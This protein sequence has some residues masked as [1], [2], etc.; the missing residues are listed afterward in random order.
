M[1]NR[2][3]NAKIENGVFSPITIEKASAFCPAI[4]NQEQASHMSRHYKPISTTEVLEYTQSKGYGISQ[5]Q[6]KNFHQKRIDAGLADNTKANHLIRLRHMNAPSHRLGVYPELVFV[7]SFDGTAAFS[8]FAGLFRLVCSNGLIVQDKSQ[9]SFRIIHK[10]DIY[11][12]LEESIKTVV[13]NCM[14][15]IELAEILENRILNDLEQMEFAR[16]SLETRWPLVDGTGRKIADSYPVSQSQIL[17]PRRNEDS[18]NNAWEILNRVQ[19]NLVSPPSTMLMRSRGNV[20]TNDRKIRGISGIADTVRINRG[21]WD[22]IRTVV[23]I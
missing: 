10:G 13:A 21:V 19:E 17:A 12:L 14:N 23:N 2:S 9:G 5:I 11:D 3:L 16:L 22:A 15:S 7:N 6:V 1:S 18:K 20:R 4:T 8:M